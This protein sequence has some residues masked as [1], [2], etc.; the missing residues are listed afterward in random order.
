MLENKKI[1]LQLQFF[2]GR[3]EHNLRDIFLKTKNNSEK[4]NLWIKKCVNYSTENFGLNSLFVGSTRRLKRLKILINILREYEIN[5]LEKTS[6]SDNCIALNKRDYSIKTHKKNLKILTSKYYL[7][8]QY[9][10]R[11]IKSILNHK[12]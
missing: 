6:F 12:N 11:I 9:L 3:Q 7:F 8:K 10:I 5:K 1:F 2:G 4:E